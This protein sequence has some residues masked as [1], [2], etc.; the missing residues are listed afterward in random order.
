[1]SRAGAPKTTQISIRVPDE[2]LAQID[3]L[4]TLMQRPRSFVVVQALRDFV[5]AELEDARSV[6]QEVADIEAHPEAG[7]PHED[8]LDWLI[9]H[10]AL[11]RDA[12][13]AA[14]QRHAS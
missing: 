9:E 8:V 3:E 5:A 4:A 2:V 12:V 11:T 1:M 13:E 10:G 14:R 6:A 7:V